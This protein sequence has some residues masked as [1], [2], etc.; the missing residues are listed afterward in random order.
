M[1]VQTLP[2]FPDLI[3]NVL[4]SSRIRSGMSESN[5]RRRTSPDTY[6]E[7]GNQE[8][9]PMG[10][11]R[12]VT[13]KRT[14]YQSP[15]KAFLARS[16]STALKLLDQAKSR[17][18]SEPNRRQSLRDAVLGNKSNQ[19]AL[20]TPGQQTQTG[21]TNTESQRRDDVTSWI[22]NSF[23]DIPPADPAP[24]IPTP[25]RPYYPP[26]PSSAII[27]RL[28]K[29]HT[30][31][32]TERARRSTSVEL[33]PTPVQLGKETAPE[34]P[35]GLLSSPGG[36]GRK[37][38]RVRNENVHS[39]P[40]KARDLPPMHAEEVEEHEEIASGIGDEVEDSPTNSGN[41]VHDDSIDEVVNDVEPEEELTPKTSL[42]QAEDNE[43]PV[44]QEKLLKLKAFQEQL[45]ALKTK[46][47]KL[48]AL[49]KSF[50]ESDMQDSTQRSQA[51]EL[52][53]AGYEDAH[54]SLVPRSEDQQIFKQN[55]EKYLTIFAPH[56]LR[57][58]YETWEQTTKGSQK[59]VY[60]TTFAAPACWP[61]STLLAT[62]DVVVDLE[63]ER[64]EAV[65]YMPDSS[66]SRPLAEWIAEKTADPLT[67]RDMATISAG[68]SAYFCEATKRAKVFRYL[69]DARDATDPSKIQPDLHAP[70]TDSVEAS[71]LRQYIAES[72]FA[73]QLSN[74]QNTRTR[75]SLGSAKQI[76]LTYDISLD[77]IGTATARVDL[78][79][80]G[81][82]ESTMN[83]A[84]KLFREKLDVDGVV[85]AFYAIKSILG[86][87]GDSIKGKAATAK[88]KG[89]ETRRMTAAEF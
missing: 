80:S 57:M 2:V 66:I 13:P 53:L 22:E 32:S 5:K 43:D 81:F 42:E 24:L 8:N 27:P 78:T 45:Q 59:F 20:H 56:G 11:D 48:E 40:L 4:H 63:T 46:C 36:S 7:V 33:P 71:S 9:V 67:R 85:L 61:R 58:S 34:R 37:R 68:V 50:S 25:K 65:K 73:Y 26:P 30:T 17:R 55:A 21:E 72:S 87:D 83:S 41:I 88:R 79:G 49:S 76:M 10:S 82:T 74:G 3:S 47:S 23:R 54:D 16:N 64:I 38:V 35:R 28:V 39:S 18:E 6:V 51:A 69:E 89:K 29:D 62:F 12:P 75:R 84:R 60:Q 86:S 19:Q 15:T 70:V 14:S 77:W 44:I 31:A 1:F 52:L